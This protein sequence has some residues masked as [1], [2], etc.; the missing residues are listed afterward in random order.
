MINYIM[1]CPWFLRMEIAVTKDAH[2]Q[3]ASNAM[4][5]DIWLLTVNCE[6]ILWAVYIRLVVLCKSRTTCVYHFLLLA[7]E[8]GQPWKPY[9]INSSMDKHAHGPVIWHALL[10]T[11]C[12]DRKSMQ[13][14]H[15]PGLA[16]AAA[17][18]HHKCQLSWGWLLDSRTPLLFCC[19]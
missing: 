11:L 19:I 1:T 15:E 18:I 5:Q 2:G 12:W 6:W 16:A 13:C 17:S 10:W 14:G 3:L 4:H 8:T 7:P 9:H